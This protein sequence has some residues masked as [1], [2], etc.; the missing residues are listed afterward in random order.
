MALEHFCSKISIFQFH[1]PQT[2]KI[3]L[4]MTQN[5]RWIKTDGAVLW[6]ESKAPSCNANIPYGPYFLCF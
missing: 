2:S 5:E 4:F 6:H 1:F 3:H